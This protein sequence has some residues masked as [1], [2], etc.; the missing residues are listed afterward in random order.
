MGN[1][2]DMMSEIY[3]LFL[4]FSLVLGSLGI[5]IYAERHNI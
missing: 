2:V 3:F 5:M 4:G 1:M